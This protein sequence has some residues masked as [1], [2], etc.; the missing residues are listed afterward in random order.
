MFKKLGI[1]PALMVTAIGVMA[2]LAAQA[3]PERYH[4]DSN[5]YSRTDGWVCTQ[6]SGK[7]GRLNL[8]TNPDLSAGVRAKL[9]KGERFQDLEKTTYNDGYV[10]RKIVVSV[11]AS[12]A[13]GWAAQK[14]LCL[15]H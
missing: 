5:H 1:A 11:G 9:P 2:P 12:G 3:H 14:Y 6:D 15:D 7:A 10:W 4:V 13:R 8:R